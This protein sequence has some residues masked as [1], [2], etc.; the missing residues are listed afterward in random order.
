MPYIDTITG[1]YIFANEIL[2]F[3][4]YFLFFLKA[5]IPSIY[6]QS[7]ITSVAMQIIIVAM[8]LSMLNNLIHAMVKIRNWIK[9]R[10]YLKIRPASTPNKQ[11]GA[12]GS[13]TFWVEKTNH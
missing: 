2:T 5:L 7:T 12:L 4:F 1:W 10:R 9:K 6:K 11:N 13:D 3:I 8:S